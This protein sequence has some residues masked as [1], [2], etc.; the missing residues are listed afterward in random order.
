MS[1]IAELRIAADDFE[2]GR[3]LTAN[4]D[5]TIELDGMVPKDG[6]PTPLWWRRSA[7]PEAFVETLR[8]HP[9]VADATSMGVI[10]GRTLFT[11]D[12]DAEDALFETISAHDGTV[13]DVVGTPDQWEF[14][15]EFPSQQALTAYVTA[16]ENNGIHPETTRVSTPSD[17][18]PEF[19][20]TEP[21]LETLTLAVEWG[22]YDIPRG[23]TTKELADEFGISD[24]AV[25]ERLRR[26]I[27]TL[28]S[29]TLI[30]D[31]EVDD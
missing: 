10:D 28:V 24:Q 14:E 12:Y 3:I 17:A 7:T 13:L 31:D 20:L 25:T 2:L 18:D 5:A 22:Y 23:C 9:S 8:S 1:V 6:T 11:L 19:G 21:Q 30:D 26:A 15:L 27:E 4:R 29:N 16:C